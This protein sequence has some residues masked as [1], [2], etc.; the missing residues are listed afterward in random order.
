MV[1]DFYNLIAD[2]SK[3]HKQLKNEPTF[4]EISGYPHYE[5]VCSNILAFF[6]DPQNAHG[7]SDLIL[8]SIMECA[9]M[10][11]VERLSDVEVVREDIAGTGRI[12]L[13]IKSD[14]HVIAIENKIYHHT[15]SN[16]FDKYIKKIEDLPG[17]QIK[18]F[19]LLGLDK[20]GPKGKFKPITYP[21]VFTKVRKNLG[22]YIVDANN[23]YL[24]FFL[25]FMKTIENLV[26]GNQMDKEWV[27]F[28]KKYQDDVTLLVN[29]FKIFRNELHKKVTGLGALLEI[30]GQEGK[31]K[32][33]Y[34]GGSN[35]LWDSLI[36]D[37]TIESNFTVVVDCSIHPHGWEIEIYERFNKQTDKIKELLE[38]KNIISERGSDYHKLKLKE[39]SFEEKIEIVAKEC[40]TIINKLLE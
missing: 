29:T 33:Q 19:I 20:K 9:G 26:G 30:S 35:E 32:Q 16:P 28:F 38:K 27:D 21:Q 12:D 24:V 1:S 13:V 2:F 7:L 11:H 31:I 4:L 22:E 5:N 34:I 17:E 25:E 3:I 8:R 10:N 37:L 40:S 23:K 14:S 15:D 18:I 39:F 36:Y 6:L